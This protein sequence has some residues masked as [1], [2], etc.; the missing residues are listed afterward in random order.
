LGTSMIESFKRNK[1]H[2]LAAVVLFVLCFV[3]YS[4]SLHN[5]F[6]IDDYGLIL[7]NPQIR[8]INFFLNNFIP[9]DHPK[10]K[11]VY[12]RPIP[13]AL[14]M[15]NYL[16]F[17]ANPFGYHLLNLFAF[18]LCCLCVYGFLNILL[19]DGR[20]SL[21]A[22]L[23]FCSHPINGMLVNYKTATGYSVLICSVM[24]SLTFYLLVEQKNN[25]S[26]LVISYLW[27]FI[28][29]LCHEIAM[30]FPLYLAAGLFFIKKYR[31]KQIIKGCFPYGVILFI[32]FIFRLKVASLKSNIIN[33]IPIFEMSLTNYLATFSKLV[34]WYISKLV[35]LNDIVLIWATPLVR[36]PLLGWNLIFIC[37]VLGC[38]YLIFVVWKKDIR[39]FA[40]FWILIGFIPVTMAC[41]F[42][43]DLGLM[44]EPHWLFFA[45][46]GFFIFLA[47]LI[48]RGGEKFNKNLIPI[49]SMILLVAYVLAS[50][51]HNY[52]WANEKRYCQF[53]LRIVPGYKSVMF[54]LANCYMRDGEYE[55]ARKLSEQALAGQFDDWQIYTNLGLM[56]YQEEKFTLAIEKFRT[57]LKFNPDSAVT[58]ND[59]GNAL[60]KI[61]D[62][63]MAQQSFLK[64]IG[65]NPFLL[66][67]RLNLASIYQQQGEYEKAIALLKRN[68]AIDPNNEPSLFLLAEMDLSAG[69]KP[70]AL[71]LAKQLLVKG[72]DPEALVGLGSLFAANRYSKMAFALCSRALQIDPYNKNAHLQLGKLYGNAEQF[73]RAI[74]IWQEG[75]RYH[76]DE[77]EFKEL[78]TEAN[79]LM[80][81]K[82]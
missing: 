23:F 43:T 30:A 18:Y 69:N 33:K 62:R 21:L 53:W 41:L 70:S 8:S 40:V 10:A 32:Y 78:I 81:H 34:F 12:Y 57:A 66:E 46:I 51:Q 20:V 36:H 63:K 31:L 2:W 13:H 54:H 25:K 9:V 50:R 79:E 49:L 80:V 73:N 56:D 60:L 29:L 35:T 58:Y 14:I 59:L 38:L 3:T 82:N 72:K 75:L 77:P 28:A 39:A 26:Y 67:P 17:G 37:I 7:E 42:H 65:L 22:S 74:V 48:V 15:L 27:F 55:K 11:I 45:S 47:Y 61:N 16:L 6:M 64:A 71:E 4:N 44:I 5:D 1:Q 19:R 76:P 24:L 52:L 68:L